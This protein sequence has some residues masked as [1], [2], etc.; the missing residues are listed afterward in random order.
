MS[1]APCESSTPTPPLPAKKLSDRVYLLG[2]T[3]DGRFLI[4][5]HAR[6]M[7]LCLRSMAMVMVSTHAE[8]GFVDD[9]QRRLGQAKFG[10]RLME[11][12]VAVGPTRVMAWLDK[13]SRDVEKATYIELDK[14]EVARI[15]GSARA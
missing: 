3:E 6:R 12:C 11:E 14:G 10:Q 9:E 13:W 4:Y 7:L 5:D 2:Y 8:L 15:V 1:A